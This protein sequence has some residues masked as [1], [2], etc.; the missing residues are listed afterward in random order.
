MKTDRNK[1]VIGTLL[2]G[3][4][5]IL[6]L[7][8][9]AIGL[10]VVSDISE[11]L[12]AEALAEPVEARLSLVETQ[13]Q[14]MN[15]GDSWEYDIAQIL[16]CVDDIDINPDDYGPDRRSWEAQI[17]HAGGAQTLGTF[18]PVGAGLHFIDGR[19]NSGGTVDLKVGTA[20]EMRAQQRN[21]GVS[22][23]WEQWSDWRPC[24]VLLP[25]Y[26]ETPGQSTWLPTP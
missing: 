26:P 3:V 14:L 1:L 16:T 24:G 4:G 10:M 15:L 6:A 25:R 2:V 19:T 9:T 7:G 20:Y 5:A 12:P 23:P 22:T 11:P 8:A 17:R 13:L 21:A 18:T